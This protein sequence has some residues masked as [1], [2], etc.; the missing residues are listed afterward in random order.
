MALNLIE[1]IALATDM[2]V[3]TNPGNRKRT[4]RASNRVEGERRDN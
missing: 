4:W 3:A 2:P 1:K